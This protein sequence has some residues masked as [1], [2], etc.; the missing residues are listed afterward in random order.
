MTCKLCTGVLGV[1][2]RHISGRDSSSPCHFMLLN[3][4]DL[5]LVFQMFHITYKYHYIV[6]KKSFD[7]DHHQHSD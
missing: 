2:Q 7:T 4:L 3:I 1:A 6:T 5:V